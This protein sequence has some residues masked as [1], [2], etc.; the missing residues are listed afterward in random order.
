MVAERV[1]ASHRVGLGADAADGATRSSNRIGANA[2]S[3]VERHHEALGL[4]ER[5]RAD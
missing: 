2:R 4:S 5:Q 1:A 3:D